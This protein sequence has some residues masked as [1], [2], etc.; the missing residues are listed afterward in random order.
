MKSW[1]DP[2]GSVRPLTGLDCKRIIITVEL[3]WA[4]LKTEHETAVV[5]S[6]SGHNN[7]FNYVPPTW[8]KFNHVESIVEHK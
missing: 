6:V 7:T 8:T 3:D 5:N 2:I 4:S 1:Q